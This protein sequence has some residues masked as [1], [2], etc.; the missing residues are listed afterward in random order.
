MKLLKDTEQDRL[1]ALLKALET[2]IPESL[3]QE[4]LDVTE[5]VRPLRRRRQPK[6]LTQAA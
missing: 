6:A 1:V 5:S 3:W 4:Y 2:H